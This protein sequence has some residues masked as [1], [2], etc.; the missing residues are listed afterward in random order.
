MDN[1]YLN[2]E[3]TEGSGDINRLED[4]TLNF[5]SNDMEY[6]L[7]I[8]CNGFFPSLNEYHDRDD[9][10]KGFYT[11]SFWFD[12]DN[13]LKL[14]MDLLNWYSCYEGTTEAALS[15]IIDIVL[16]C[17]NECSRQYKYLT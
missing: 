3:L 17:M 12:D 2:V 4:I 11:A 13:I 8:D 5:Y 10:D 1:E 9:N 7:S 16:D 15:Q 6:A 14:N